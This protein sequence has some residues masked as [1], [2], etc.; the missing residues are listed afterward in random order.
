MS[1]S[2]VDPDQHFGLWTVLAADHSSR[3]ASCR[4]RCGVIRQVTFNALLSGESRGCGCC[5]RPT[6]EEINRA[7]QGSGAGLSLTGGRAGDRTRLSFPGAAMWDGM[8]D[9]PPLI[10]ESQAMPRLF[11]RGLV[12][13]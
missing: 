12:P 5:A 3:R 11:W 8:W 10:G 6:Q 1:A 13:V 2:A 4:C 9:Q 7:R